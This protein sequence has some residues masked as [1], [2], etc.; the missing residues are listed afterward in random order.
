ML[1][2]NDEIYKL[3]PKEIT[4]IEEHFHNKFP[5]RVTYPPERIIPSRLKHNKLPDKPNSISFD[6]KAIV[7]SDNGSEIWRYAENIIID[8]KGRKRYTP[9][10]FI[11]SGVRMLDRKEIELIYFLLNKSEFCQGGKN[12]GRMVKFMFEDLV[13]DAEKKVEKRKLNAKLDMLLYGEELAVPEEKLR[14]V[15][16]AYFIQGVDAFTLSQV[17]LALETKIKE[18]KDGIHKFFE[19]VNAD[20]EIKTR[21]SITRAIDMGILV[22]EDKGKARSWVWKTSQGTESIFKVPP[23][24]SPNEAL[25]EYYIG[26]QGFRDDLQSVLL[27]KNPNAG[28]KKGKGDEDT[29]T[30]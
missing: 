10:K 24:K 5:L 29:E 15:A 4:A 1:Y 28:K 23:D 8:E 21:V 30:T 13:T 27:T 2:K 20:E 9:K 18:D 26:N 6:L 14:D 3:N 7:K 11:F 22:M 16:K 19:M 17:K 25:Y 12:E